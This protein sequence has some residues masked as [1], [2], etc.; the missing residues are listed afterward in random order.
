MV[1]LSSFRSVR[2][3]G[4][5]KFWRKKF[6]FDQSTHFYGR[7]RNCY[8]VA[9]RA[10]QRAWQFSFRSRKVKKRS[11]RELW[12][13]RISA[14]AREHGM[15]YSSF[16]AN[17]S[18]CNIRIDRKML[19][20]LAIFEPRS[21][22]S[23]VELAKEKQEETLIQQLKNNPDVLIHRLNTQEDLLSEGLQSLEVKGS[24]LGGGKQLADGTPV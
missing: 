12:N 3:R 10:V 2:A 24:V 17:I 18:R 14:A 20:N 7:R 16:M 5:D 6:I 11:I 15:R 13:M 23:L 1:F 22:Q 8:R 19:S 21:F 4:P 9:V